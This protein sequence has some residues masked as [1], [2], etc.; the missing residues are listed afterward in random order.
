MLRAGQPHNAT[1]E[2]KQLIG[3]WSDP[4]ARNAPLQFGNLFDVASF[5]MAS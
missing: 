1:E 2:K 5:G 3:I 4:S